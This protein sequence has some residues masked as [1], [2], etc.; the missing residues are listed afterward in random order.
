MTKKQYTIIIICFAFIGLKCVAQQRTIKPDLAN[1]SHFQLVNRDINVYEN[2][3]KKTVVHLTNRPGDGVAWI[4]S[5]SFQK[6]ILEFD[7]K[8]KNVLQ[9][10]FVG[11][12][13]HGL[14]DSTFDAIYFRPFNFQSPDTIRKSHSVQYISVPHYDWSTLR[15]KYPGKYEHSLASTVD[16]E[17][18]FHAK[19]IVD[20]GALIVYLNDDKSP[21]LQVKLIADR[22]TG[23]IGFWVGN[24][25]DGDF[26]NL[27][28]IHN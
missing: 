23:K 9:Q 2:E 19:I 25:S 17:K 27:T 16:P 7:V 3:D 10:S 22:T 5:V 11:I 13:F 28:I 4:N 18:W 1:S 12:A 14:N 20:A 6:G 15:E 8:G 21:S 26:S 24:N